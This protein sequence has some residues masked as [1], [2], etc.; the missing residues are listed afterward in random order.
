MEIKIEYPIYRKLSNNRSFYKIVDSK[1]FEEIQIIGT[2]KIHKLFRAKK[3]PEL[4]F[5][6]DLI[7]LNHLGLLEIT[8]EE[9]LAIV[10][11][12]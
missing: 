1:I 7:A 6:Q 3:Y 2:K 10:N 8:E 5:I 9:W 4:L 12:L 11:R